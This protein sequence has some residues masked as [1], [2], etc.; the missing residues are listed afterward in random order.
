ME[1]KFLS[2]FALLPLLGL[3]SSCSFYGLFPDRFVDSPPYDILEKAAPSE[4]SSYD[5]AKNQGR[6]GLLPKGDQRTLVLP[7]AFSDY[8]FSDQELRNLEI[9]FNG[10]P[11]ETGYW[12]SVS[13]FYEKSSFG[14]LHLHSDIAPVYTVEDTANGYMSKSAHSGRRSLDLMKEAVAHFAEEGGDTDLYDNDGDGYIDGLYV[15]YAAPSYMSEAGKGLTSEFWAFTYWDT[16]AETGDQAVGN[17]YVFASVKFME[18]G[19]KGIDAHTY[20]HETGHLLGLE[21]YY[22]YD[23][24][25][26]NLSVNAKYRHYCPTGGFDMMDY[27]ITDHNVATK[28]LLGWNSPYVV[29]SDLSFPLR[30][31]LNSS[32]LGGDFI[33]IP[34]IEEDYNGTPFGEY[35]I[36]ELYEPDG[37]NYLDANYSYLG[38]PSAYKTPGLKIFHADFRL[39]QRSG[40]LYGKELTDPTVEDLTRYDGQPHSVRYV[41]GASNTPSSSL[42]AG[43]RQLHLLESSGELTFDKL[44]N[45]AYPTGN[46]GTL[47]KAK[48]GRG[49][50]DMDKFSPFFENGAKFNS[51]KEFG[52]ILTVESLGYDEEGSLK[53]IIEIDKE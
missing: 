39:Y 15:I 46:E 28:W 27:N 47:F 26:N 44:N 50:F 42:K 34:S 19:T 6:G 43:Y 17:A 49:Y 29:T 12:E 10:E 30:V 48:E 11:E 36:L 23:L 1:K 8:T 41:I 38:Y 18:A 9:A 35:L 4:V 3:L 52:Y 45:G 16:F 32:F 5:L 2:F 22:N 53:A 51:G 25:N 20:I 14:Q 13:S 31:E 40:N 24:L 33:A 21:D 7:V 37:L